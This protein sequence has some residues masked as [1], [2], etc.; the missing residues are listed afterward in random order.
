VFFGAQVL[1]GNVGRSILGPLA[2]KASVDALNARLGVDRPLVVQYADWISSF[3]RGDLGES[4][5]FGRPVGGLVWDAMQNSVK[6]AAVAFVIVVPLAIA[7]GVIAALNEGGFRDRFITV[8]GLSATVVPEFVSGILVILVFGLWLDLLPITAQAPPGSGLFTQIKYLI[9]P[10]LPLVFVLFGYIA[11]MA[12]AG[13]IEALEADYTR[14]AILKGLPRRTVIRRHVLRN[15]LLP[16]I[17]VVATQTGYLIGGLVVIETLFNYQGI[18]RLIFQAA[19][20]KDFPLLESG[21]LVIGIVYL[22]A[23]LLADLA[24]SLLNPRIRYASTE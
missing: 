10:S 17:A 24:Y 15:A 13:T 11:R 14:T 12:R 20:Q 22:V 9:L 8:T 7:G 4:L 6:L 16:T 5:V 19:T 21:V 3:F 18:G 23:T 2:D 1:P